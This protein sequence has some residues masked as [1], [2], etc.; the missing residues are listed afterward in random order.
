[1]IELSSD[2]TKLRNIEQLKV[3]DQWS[4]DVSPR[5]HDEF[6]RI[7]FSTAQL[8]NNYLFRRRL[9]RHFPGMTLPPK[10]PSRK[11]CAAMNYLLREKQHDNC[12]A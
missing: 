4:M 7:T 8:L 1:M 3:K 11:W 2:G 10:I 12:T 6:V 5:G 9:L